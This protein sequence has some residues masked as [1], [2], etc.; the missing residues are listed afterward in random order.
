MLRPAG[1]TPGVSESQGWGGAQE[2]EFLAGSQVPLLWPLVWGSLS[3][4]CLARQL[5]ENLWCLFLRPALLLVRSVVWD[6]SSPPKKAISCFNALAQ[7]TP[8]PVA[9][10]RIVCAGPPV[11]FVLILPGFT[12]L[13]TFPEDR[14]S[15]S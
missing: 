13:F 6:L 2:F 10:L 1:P 5:S 7:R 4:N 11:L 14:E 8:S 12:V 15:V 3:E 9:T